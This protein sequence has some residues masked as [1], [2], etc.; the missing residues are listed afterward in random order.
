MKF[1]FNCYYKCY[2]TKSVEIESHTFDEKIFFVEYILYAY[3]LS[4]IH[5]K[6]KRKKLK[7]KF[8]INLDNL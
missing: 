2:I 3:I 5:L 8:I 7:E 1:Q 6:N 4:Q